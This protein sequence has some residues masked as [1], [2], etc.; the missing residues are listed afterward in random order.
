M[1][2][3]DP[4]GMVARRAENGPGVV[5]GLCDPA[6]DQDDAREAA[7]ARIACSERA[8]SVRL[9]PDAFRHLESACWPTSP[10][11]AGE[12]VA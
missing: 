7:G 3:V 4:W 2:C 6:R 8:A 12:A 1:L 5:A 11:R 9:S 10:Q